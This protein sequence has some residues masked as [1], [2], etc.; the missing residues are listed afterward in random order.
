MLEEKL[1]AC[2]DEESAAGGNYIAEHQTDHT[3]ISGKGTKQGQTMSQPFSLA[4]DESTMG[5]ISPSPISLGRNRAGIA[6]FQPGAVAVPG[7]GPPTPPHPSP[8]INA[9]LVLDIE[10]SSTFTKSPATAVVNAEPIKHASQ[11]GLREFLS[12]PPIQTFLI[13]LCLIT[14]RIVVGVALE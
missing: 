12:S 7:M 5:S 8:L 10:E 6:I 1:P 9:Q 3:G 11:P 13:L 4:S 14:I 2:P